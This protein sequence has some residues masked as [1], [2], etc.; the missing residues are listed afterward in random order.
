MTARPPPDTN[1]HPDRASSALF[2]GSVS[3][4]PPFLA[5]SH[6]FRRVTS[7]SFRPIGEMQLPPFLRAT[8]S[9]TVFSSFHCIT[10]APRLWTTSRPLSPMTDESSSAQ[11][12]SSFFGRGH[13]SSLPDA[14]VDKFRLWKCFSAGLLRDP[15]PL[16]ESRMGSE[17]ALLDTTRSRSV[18]P[19]RF[20]HHRLRFTSPRPRLL[21]C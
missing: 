2:R 4:R 21:T 11:C 5:K 6:H 18:G 7:S 19:A 14:S 10:H 17:R 20:G 16:V 1:L 15:F 13:L 9:R 3:C 8:V 12:A